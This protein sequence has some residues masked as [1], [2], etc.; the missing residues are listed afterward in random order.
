MRFSAFKLTVAAFCFVIQATLSAQSIVGGGYQLPTRME[1][2]PGQVVTIFVAGSGFPLAEATLAETLPLPLSLAGVAAQLRITGRGAPIDI[3]IFAVTPISSCERGLSVPCSEETMLAVTLQ[4][5]W[6]MNPSDPA[7]SLFASTEAVLTVFVGGSASGDFRILPRAD[8]IH[9]LNTCDAA[10]PFDFRDQVCQAVVT[11]A[12][13]SYVTS[14]NPALEGET[15]V[16][17]ALGLGRGQSPAVTGEAVPEPIPVPDA[18][19]RFRLRMDFAANA[20]PS[21][22]WPHTPFFAPIAPDYAGMVEGTVGLYQINVT[23]PPF[24]ESAPLCGGIVE[25]N[26]T[27]SVGGSASFD[28]VQICAALE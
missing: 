1:A 27:I 8:A 6:E 13:G 24:P 26:L 9:F 28:G 4:I 5:P 17:Y 21:P 19:R 2:A 10:L 23:V 22:P 7:G 18:D 15:I 12:D 20:R 25:S 14:E 3:P 11:H 16:L